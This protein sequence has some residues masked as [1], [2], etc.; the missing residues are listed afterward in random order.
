MIF[1]KENW[2]DLLEHY[3]SADLV[4]T[5][6]REKSTFEEKIQIKMNFKQFPKAQ[7]ELDLHGFT[8]PE[9]ELAVDR[10]LKQATHQNLRTV[11]IITGKGLHSKQGQSVLRDLIEQ[12][13]AELKRQKKILGYKWEKNRGSVL[14]YLP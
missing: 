12:L 8:G 7:T 5:A 11:R 6:L 4:H 14:V 10:F 2:A 3:T 9:A 1:Q 13:L